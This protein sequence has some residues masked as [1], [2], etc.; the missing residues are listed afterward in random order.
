MS[1]QHPKSP[2]PLL[3]V[4]IRALPAKDVQYLGQVVALPTGM[5]HKTLETGEGDTG[6][7]KITPM[8][9]V[10]LCLSDIGKLKRLRSKNLL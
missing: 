9:S 6:L 5:S 2:A 7:M 4:L 10:L 8:L 3:I 1:G